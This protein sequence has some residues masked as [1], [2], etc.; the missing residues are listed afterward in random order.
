M[1][2]LV[3]FVEGA[4]VDDDERLPTGRTSNGEDIDEIWRTQR[5]KLFE[6]HVELRRVAFLLSFCRR[7]LDLDSPELTTLILHNE[8]IFSN[9]DLRKSDVPASPEKLCHDRHLACAAHI[10]VL[11]F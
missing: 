7:R 5:F 11:L 2:E 1:V 8:N 3:F 10:Q 4:T 9:V 6:R